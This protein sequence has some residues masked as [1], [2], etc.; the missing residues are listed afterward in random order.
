[1]SSKHSTARTMAPF[2]VICSIMCLLATTVSAAPSCLGW[3]SPSTCM[4]DAT[5]GRVAWS[6]PGRGTN[7]DNS[8]ANVG[9]ATTGSN[10]L[11]CT[12]YGFVLPADALNIGI[13]VRIDRKCSKD[14][15]DEWCTD[16]ALRLVKGGL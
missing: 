7:D 9:K 5:F 14:D 10:Y 1:M 8:F 3:N 4:N 12:G 11:L 15:S 2:A 6:N 16:I 13:Q